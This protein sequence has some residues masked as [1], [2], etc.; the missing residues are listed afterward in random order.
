M[1]R[2]KWII[3]LTVIMMALPV[4]AQSSDTPRAAS[5]CVAVWFPSSSHPDGA[6]SILENL[7]V[8][9]I[10]HP[11]WYS[12]RPDGTLVIHPG[13]EDA[14]HLAAWREAGLTVVP[15]IFSS[16]FEPIMTEAGRKAH[17]AEIVG[18]VRRMDYD[19]IDIDYEGFPITTREPFTLFI[20]A[21]SEALHA[22]GKLLMVTVHAKTEAEPP[23]AAAA[24][25]DWE[26]LA[27]AA[28]IFNLMTYDYTSRNEPPGS[29]APS[30]WMRDAVTYGGS[31]T[32]PGK[33]RLGLPIYGY[34]WMRGNPPA[35]TV[36]WDGVQRWVESFGI[37]I[38][39]APES[40]E[41]FIELKARG[42]PRQNIVMND[43][44]SITHKMQTVL[45]ANPTLGGVAVWGLGGEDPEI[46]EVLRQ[47]DG[48][49]CNLETP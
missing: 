11:F 49:P 48:A 16:L 12:P 42:L 41:A 6:R 39:R 18:L 8:I 45:K 38:I 33:M 29:I 32:E 19:G 26:R 5:W 44:I 20:E 2:L 43:A 24:A 30:E 36:A 47:F 22:E 17:I 4:G 7:D 27:A 10:V 23:Y 1:N 13:A 21:L 28:D 37:E 14:E 46:W 35:Q 31:V 25:Q 34:S 40:Q 15:S 3:L 9:D